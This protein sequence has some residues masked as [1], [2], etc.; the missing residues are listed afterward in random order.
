LLHPP[1]SVRVVALLCVSV[2]LCA[3]C[4]MSAGCSRPQAEAMPPDATDMVLVPAG[5]FLMG[6]NDDTEDESPQ[7]R[8]YLDTF[9]IDRHEVTNAEFKAFCDST[10]RLL[11][12]NPMWDPNYLLDNPDKPVV[13]LTWRQAD[14]YCRW[15]GKALPT[16]A[17]WEKAAR[18]ATGFLYPWGNTFEEGRANLYGKD[19]YPRTAPVGSFP[20]GASPYGAL[21][22]AGN[23]WEWCNDWY[24]QFYYREAP[25]R[26]PPGPSEKSAWRVVRGGGFSSPTPDALAAN[27]SKNKPDLPVHHIGCRCAWSPELPP[28]E[29]Q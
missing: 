28:A 2:L 20:S 6:S 11:P 7:R 5:E 4:W 17:Q 1:G 29:N 26:N 23:V 15:R 19:D 14:A 22:M 24:Q 8:V 21:D 16:E 12:N 3:A 27:R 10:R 13:N 9:W 25:T 18:G